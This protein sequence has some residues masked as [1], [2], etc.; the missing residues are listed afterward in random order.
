MKFRPDIA[1]VLARYRDFYSAPN[2]KILIH[3]GVPLDVE[4]I[5]PKLNEFKFPD[6]WKEYARQA[7]DNFIRQQEARLALDI[8][9][10][11]IWASNPAMHGIA[12]YRKISQAF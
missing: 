11:W 10:D 4:V 8:K 1:E 3:V 7:M 9:D 12:L 5:Q 2:G 6:D